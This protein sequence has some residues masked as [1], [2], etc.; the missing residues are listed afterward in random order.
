MD[1][2][3]RGKYRCAVLLIIMFAILVTL[4]PYVFV[5]GFH[6]AGPNAHPH[7]PLHDPR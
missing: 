2:I 4:L 3:N 5:Q 6:H 1:G 7:A